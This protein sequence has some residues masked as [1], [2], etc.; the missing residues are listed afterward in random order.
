MFMYTLNEIIY[1]QNSIVYNRTCTLAPYYEG[2]LRSNVEKENGASM[3]KF[4]IVLRQ[5]LNKLYWGIEDVWHELGK[6]YVQHRIETAWT[7]CMTSV[8]FIFFKLIMIWRQSHIQMSF[9]QLGFQKHFWIITLSVYRVSSSWN[10]TL[11]VYFADKSR[12]EINISFFLLKY[13]VLNNK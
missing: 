11:N 3:L 8:L 1:P 13:I 9:I 10:Y 7:D 5:L 4:S 12:H 2:L 6:A